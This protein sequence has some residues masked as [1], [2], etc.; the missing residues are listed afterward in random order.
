MILTHI[1]QILTS[2]AVK[3]K[4]LFAVCDQLGRYMEMVRSRTQQESL[5]QS[6]YHL[7]TETK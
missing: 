2:A 3:N 6:S 4:V 1:S 5:V 7:N